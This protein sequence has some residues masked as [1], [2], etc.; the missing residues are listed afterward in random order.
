MINHLPCAPSVKPPSTP[1]PFGHW[2]VAGDRLVCTLPRKQVTVRAPGR[3]LRDIARACD[4]T[5]T[6]PQVL[7]ALGKRWCRSTL[8]PLMLALCGERVLVESGRLWAHWSDIAQLPQHG[9]ACATPDAI[10]AL[11]RSA[12][13]RILPGLG[14]W[15]DGLATGDNA[16]ARLLQ[17]R[18]STRTFGDQPITVQ[19]VCSILWAAHG[20]ARVADADAMQW[21]RTVASGGNMH[22]TRWFVAVLRELPS[23]RPG[24]HAAAAGFY[25]ARFHAEGGAS[26][27]L[28]AADPS[29][30]WSC[31]ADPRVLR[32][33]SALVLPVCDVAGP[34][35]K[36]GNRATLF[37]MMEA[38][39]CLQN[40]QLMAASLGTACIMRGD[41]V[42]SAAIALAGVD[43]G[44]GHWVSVPGLVVGSPPSAEQKRRQPAEFQLRVAPNLQLPT[45]AQI[46]SGQFAF[47]AAPVNGDQRRLLAGSGRAYDPRTAMSIAEA[48]AW[49]RVGWST[50]VH[51]IR[52]PFAELPQALDPREL[53]AFSS[54]QHRS[55]NFPFPRFD[56]ARTC[57]WTQAVNSDM[58]AGRAV[59]L[60]CVHAL[61]A[62]PAAYQATACASS[63][64]SGVAAGTCVEDALMRATLELV[65]RDA[66]CC[67]WLSGTAF[68]GIALET[69]PAALRRRMQALASCGAQAS[70]IDLSN[71]WSAVV[72]VFLQCA[73]MPFTAITAAAGFDVE[74]TLSKAISEAEGRLAFVRQFAVGENGSD[75]MRDI[76]RHYRRARTYQRSDFFRPTTSTRPFAAV[77][78]DSAQDWNQTQGRLRADGFDLLCVDI[79]P[80]GASIEQGRQPLK[81]VRALVPG[82]VPIWFHRHLQPQG[83]KRFSNAA[84]VRGGR[85]D[86]HFVHPFT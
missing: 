70:V 35:R 8:E 80:P 32:Y 12:E 36:Y 42:G 65:E 41:T 9:G 47:A 62:L 53:V 77:G 72:A 68:P 82:L 43:E 3:L 85:P 81:V 52:A 54:R 64:T 33:A 51:A 26:L 24:T 13:D 22:S 10:A 79:T 59:P 84:R 16:L 56:P 4:G 74:S 34:A 7:D 20:V 73:E 69:L 86:G 17:S 44:D 67:A 48:E 23:T 66:F 14:V 2:I 57:L 18:E 30:A 31:L 27:Q 1:V 55:A 21:H 76:E 37:A 40:A 78:Q 19:A 58:G 28:V 63:S 29:P 46:G 5:Q 83:L 60:E 38:G 50:P 6:W 45:R 49:E 61:H 11:S 71:P 39:L 15:D 75:P 25:E